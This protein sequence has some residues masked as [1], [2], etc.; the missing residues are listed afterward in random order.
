MDSNTRMIADRAAE[1]RAARVPFVHAKVVLAERPT[2]AHPGD[3][4][5]VLADGTMEGF[6][7]GDCAEATVRAQALAVLDS[8]E[9]VL[10]RISPTPEDPVPGKLMAHNPC[11]SGGTLEIFLEPHRPA[12]LVAV[13]GD[14]PIA[15]ALVAIGEALGYELV[16]RRRRPRRRLGRDRRLPRTRRGDA[17]VAALDAGV[18]YVGLVASPKRGAAVVAGLDVDPALAAQV[19]TPAGL[20]IGA[21]T[22]EEVAL[23]ILADIVARRP[24]PSAR[25]VAEGDTDEPRPRPTR[26]AGWPSPPST[27]RCTSTTTASATTSAGRAASARSPPTPTRYVR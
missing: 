16:A 10:L 7:G 12:P 6:V 23:S 11:L 27:R 8:G 25:A 18:G 26:C 15:R 17:A 2:S 20:D 13:V 3:E 24:Q 21:R 19:V 22:A 9:S 1:L 5:L 14:S 4:A